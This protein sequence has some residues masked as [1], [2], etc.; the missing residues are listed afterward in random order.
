LKSFEGLRPS[1][2]AHVRWCEHGAPI[3]LGLV[4]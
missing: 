2:S 3:K 1:F 4:L